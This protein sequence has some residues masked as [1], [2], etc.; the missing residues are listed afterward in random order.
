MLAYAPSYIGL[1]ISLLE[2]FLVPRKEVKVRFH[3]SQAVSSTHRYSDNSD[4]VWRDQ[5]DYW[6]FARR[7]IFKAGSICLFDYL[8]DSRLEGRAASN[9]RAR[10]AGSVV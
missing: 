9:R 8:D 10:R 7:Q 3:A 6:Q 4:I 1:V 5:H 2:L